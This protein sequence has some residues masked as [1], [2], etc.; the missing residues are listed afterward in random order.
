L[1]AIH[2]QNFEGVRPNTAHQ[3]CKQLNPCHPVF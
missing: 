3:V 2:V 1:V